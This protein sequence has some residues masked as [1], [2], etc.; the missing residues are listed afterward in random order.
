MTKL[1][2]TSKISIHEYLMNRGWHY[3]GSQEDC[4]E[5]DIDGITEI[6]DKRSALE[7]EAKRGNDNE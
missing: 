1:S 2:Q 5:K 4:Y 3:R 6:M 7:H